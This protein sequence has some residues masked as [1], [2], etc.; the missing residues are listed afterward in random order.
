MYGQAASLLAVAGL[1]NDEYQRVSAEVV[2][3][4][5][6]LGTD[7][8]LGP[9]AAALLMGLPEQA[10]SD[11]A[12][13][14][15]ERCLASLDVE[16]DDYQQYAPVGSVVRCRFWT[17]QSAAI[18]LGA[19]GISPPSCTAVAAALIDGQ[20][21]SIGWLAVVDPII[22]ERCGHREFS[23][24][25]LLDGSLPARVAAFP[26]Q[27]VEP[28]AL[29]EA[30]WITD[31]TL[32]EFRSELLGEAAY[33]RAFDPF[34]LSLGVGLG[35]S[36]PGDAQ[37]FEDFVALARAA[38]SGQVAMGPDALSLWLMQDIAKLGG[39]QLAVQTSRARN[40]LTGAEL[41]VLRIMGQDVEG[42]AIRPA[43][44]PEMSMFYWMM[45]IDLVDATG[46]CGGLDVLGP[47]PSTPLI[48]EAYEYVATLC[49]PNFAQ[50]G[51]VKLSVAQVAEPVLGMAQPLDLQRA[52]S[53]ALRCRL[54]LSPS[55][56]EIRTAPYPTD[57]WALWTVA[58]LTENCA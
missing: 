11:A 21:G 32:N 53:R 9:A 26:A 42:I 56:P 28:L 50:F 4:L 20:L 39:T 19:V 18:D 17:S 34:W 2:E 16:P 43:R 5:E 45:V 7:H 3:S 30:G 31:A 55:L 48:T 33:N 15:I 38:A 12:R 40:G 22:R 36:E 49:D 58:V 27:F 57:L 13:R 41:V 37:M 23:L 10:P 54:G 51:D 6:S 44:N 29:H 1:N 46:S 8:F 24:D 35:L 52:I 14:Y 47:D 25:S